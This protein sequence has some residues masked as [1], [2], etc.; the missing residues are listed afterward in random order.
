MN[1]NMRLLGGGLFDNYKI[2][3]SNIISFS[4]QGSSHEEVDALGDVFMWGEGVGDGIL[5]EL[6]RLS[7]ITSHQ[8]ICICFCIPIVFLFR[9]QGLSKALDNV[10]MLSN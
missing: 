10:M 7:I 6:P 4:S 9:L 3:M 8:L 5:R 2:S 1:A